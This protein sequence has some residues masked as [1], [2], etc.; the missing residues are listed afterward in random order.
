M[1][2]PV[3]YVCKCGK[4]HSLIIHWPDGMTYLSCG[5]RIDNKKLL[6]Q[7]KNKGKL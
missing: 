4:V 1:E 3:K 7:N 6:E 5:K 2:T